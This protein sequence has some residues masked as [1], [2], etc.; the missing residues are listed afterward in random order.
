MGIAP[1]VVPSPSKDNT[2]LRQKDD[3]PDEV[4]SFTGTEVNFLAADPKQKCELW[5]ESRSLADPPSDSL[6]PVRPVQ[7]GVS[8]VPY[9][10]S[11][12][13]TST[14]RSYLGENK[15]VRRINFSPSHRSTAGKENASVNDESYCATAIC[16][17]PP[18]VG[19]SLIA[20][21]VTSTKPERTTRSAILTDSAASDSAPDLDLP[22]VSQTTTHQV[23]LLSES[24]E[25][26]KS[27]GKRKSNRK[28]ACNAP[29]AD[30]SV[31]PSLSA[32]KITARKPENYT[33][34]TI[35][36]DSAASDSA[37][38]S[39]FP[40]VSQTTTHQAPLSST[41]SEISKSI[42]RRKSNRKAACNTITVESCDESWG[43]SDASI[44]MESAASDD[45]SSGDSS[46]YKATPHSSKIR[47]LELAEMEDSDDERQCV[48]QKKMRKRK[49]KC[50]MQQRR[51]GSEKILTKRKPPHTCKRKRCQDIITDEVGDSIFSEYWEQESYEKRVQYVSSRVEIV[52]VKTK[53][54]RLQPGHEKSHPKSVT[55]KYF[56]HI[57]GEA[58]P[59]C[60]ETFLGTLGET[61]G[62]LR[63]GVSKKQKSVSG[64][65][66]QDKRGKHTPKHK[67]KPETVEE[68][69][70]HVLGFPSYKF[71]YKRSEVGDTRYLPSHLDI[72]QMY[73]MYIDEGHTFVSYSTYERIFNTLGRSFKKPSTDTCQKCDSWQQ[74][75]REEKDPQKRE[76]IE[77]LRNAHLDRAQAAY[78]LKRKLKEEA[79]SDPSLRVLIFDLEQVLE[80]P[81]L[82]TGA[83]FYLR[84]LSTYNLTIYDSTTKKTHCYMWSEIDG[85]RGANEIASCIYYHCLDV[86]PDTVKKIVLFSD[87]T[88][89][90]NRNSILA[91]MFL[92]LVQI[93][94]SIQTVEHVFLEVGHTRMEVDCKH[95]IIERKKLHTDKINVPSD[96]F[97]L[98]RKLGEPTPQYPL[99]RF[100]VTE[101]KGEFY[102][103]Q[104]LLK[105]PLVLRQHTTL[106]QKFSWMTTPLL[107]YEA[108]HPGKVFFKKSLQE[109]GY[110]C[111]DFKRRGKAG[112]YDA[113]N[114]S[115]HR[116]RLHVKPLP[117]SKEKKNDLLK[118]LPLIPTSAHDFYKSIQVHG[119]DDDFYDKDSDEMTAEESDGEEL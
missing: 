82:S 72:R 89:G 42:G 5:L 67:L 62:F 86:I 50:Q 70:T 105:G 74:M 87:S 8:L 103:F 102:D 115:R 93:H 97:D 39:D 48:P 101:M 33:R 20:D 10:P 18:S 66:Q 46:S 85:N 36:T 43:D 26:S 56:F 4:S 45:S 69:T 34:S 44:Y 92:L 30:K 49:K 54:L 53:R 51:K 90:Q 22:A 60:K 35:P 76:E 119:G 38:N 2:S 59:V 100:S 52:P 77:R 41:C 96:W 13:S 32:D 64:T 7:T 25:I 113:A 17:Q 3:Y 110:S 88:T 6:S 75:L 24:S 84:Q 106:K 23:A 61:D 11:A 91:A 80:T 47:N 68:V 104:S 58:K 19:P 118:L 98:V 71:H 29:T 114:L 111:L 116:K 14:R 40:A 9:T 16:A 78:D 79:Q 99:S 1:P 109:K 107:R 57:H 95:S 28:Y 112:E 37:P 117:I 83:A 63:F 21:K 31:S 55:H 65:V 12:S 27:D 15:L 94:A 81:L 73:N 108:K